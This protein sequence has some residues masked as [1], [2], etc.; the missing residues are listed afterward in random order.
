[1]FIVYN[2]IYIVVLP[3]FILRDFF[4]NGIGDIKF[5]AKKFGLGLE[6][7]DEP[8]LW[9]HGVSLGEVKILTPIARSLLNKNK[10]KRVIFPSRWFGDEYEHKTDDMFPSSWNSI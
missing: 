4:R 8:H 9:L 10:N 1:M 2:L 7:S 5:F 3:I 6:T